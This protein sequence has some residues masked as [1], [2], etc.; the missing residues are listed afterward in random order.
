MAWLPRL[1]VYRHNLDEYFYN[2]RMRGEVAHR[3][4]ERVRVT[5]DPMAD[6]DRAV[7]LAM[8]E[9]PALGG[10]PDDELARLEADLRD[11]TAW[12]LGNDSLRLWLTRGRR[13]PEV[14]DTDGS[15]KRLDLLCHGEPTVVADFK[16]GQP[17][18]KN[19]EQVLDY[20]R[21]L[22]DMPDVPGPVEGYLV[23]LDLREIHRVEGEA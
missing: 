3:V 20:M 14:M 7:R 1:R 5:G 12:A 10:L 9:F 19:R 15:F 11:M 13:E 23:Y 8:R 21:I 16:T 6:T 2:E 4:M 17:S 22:E 18:P